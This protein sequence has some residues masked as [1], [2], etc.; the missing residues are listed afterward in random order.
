MTQN[1]VN[2]KN[3]V[4]QF[5]STSSTGTNASTTTIP[6]DDTIPQNTEGNELFT[7]SITPTLTTSKLLIE[8]YAQLRV[9]VTVNY[10]LY[11]LF[12]DSTANAL[13]AVAVRQNKDNVLRYVMTSGTTSSTTFK[14]RIGQEGAGTI[15]TNST[16]AGA[17][18]MGGVSTA[19]LSITEYYA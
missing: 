13:A 4:L 10:M 2:A 8:F 15:W 5:L 12:Q 14:I 3:I 6:Y 16:N 18:I 7:L 17:R 1:S 11:A 9:A 19:W